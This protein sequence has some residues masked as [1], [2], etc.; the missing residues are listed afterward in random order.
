MHHLCNDSIPLYQEFLYSIGGVDAVDT[1]KLIVYIREPDRFDNISKLWKFAGF[2][3]IKYCSGCKKE[4]DYCRCGGTSFYIGSQKQKKGK[5]KSFNKD[6]KR[7]LVDIGE[8]IIK[9]DLF[10]KSMYH[11]YKTQEISK[12][13][14]LTPMHAHN[15]A[16][17]KVIKL[18]LYHVLSAWL[19]LEG[20]RVEKPY[21]RLPPYTDS[22]GDYN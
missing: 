18:F 11:D 10:Y 8:R 12:G 15:R 3:P 9:K 21:M 20:K 5:E 1:L 22:G 6:F 14:Y 2:S 16:R 13:N 4:K 17:R 7:V 19:I